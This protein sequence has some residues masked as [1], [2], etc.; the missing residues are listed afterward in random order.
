ML[1]QITDGTPNILE[2]N[3]VAVSNSIENVRFNQINERQERQIS[4]GQQD[5]RFKL[6]ATSR[7]RVI[8]APD[9]RAK[10]RLWDLKPMR[11]LGNAVGGN[12]TRIATTVNVDLP[13]PVA[14]SENS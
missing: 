3:V 10:G 5:N 4:V 1:S 13:F 11:R 2:R 8:A 14:C 6:R 12:L 9:P 7:G